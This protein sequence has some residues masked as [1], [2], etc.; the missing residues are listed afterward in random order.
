MKESVQKP[1]INRRV[2]K[3]YDPLLGRQY[4]SMDDMSNATETSESPGAHHARKHPPTTLNWRA[5]FQRQ[6][7]YKVVCGE[8][9][10]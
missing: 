6:M 1:K 9:E 8:I 3:E 5:L 4:Q 7:S 10:I 2:T